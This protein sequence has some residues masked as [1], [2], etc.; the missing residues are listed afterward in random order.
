MAHYNCVSVEASPN[1]SDKGSHRILVVDDEPTLE[2]LIRL[3]MRREIR[4]GHFAFAF[5]RNGIEALARLSSDEPYDIVL[6]D[7]NMPKMDGLTL[8]EKIPGVAP[9]IRAVIV[10]AYG[11]M[12][13][14]RTAMNRGAFDFVTKPIDFADLRTTIDRTLRDLAAWREVLK[15]RD[16]LVAIERELELAR[17]MQ[18]SI[19]PTEFPDSAGHQIFARMDPAKA[20]GGDFFDFVNLG[21]SRVGLAIADVA[22][23]GVPA[24]LL[25]MSSRTLL[26]CGAIESNNPGKVLSYVNSALQTDNAA[27]MFVTMFYGIFDSGSGKFT[28][29]SAGHDPPLLVRKDGST[30]LLPPT[31]GTVLGVIPS[32]EYQCNAIDLAPGET[33]LLYTDGVPDAH[34]VHGERFGMERFRQVFIDAP[35]EC[36]QAATEVVFQAV[37]EFAQDTPQFDDVTCLVLR[38]LGLAS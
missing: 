17:R 30:S 4:S 7:I 37:R 9:D 32:L 36:A 13:N 15:S 38:R 24:A 19:L 10:S 16:Q 11:D 31:G 21:N 26:K 28:Y 20:V 25:M 29:A 2:R 5:A 1:T 3:R 18:R 35:P 33:I 6:S 34:N 14:I 23:K 12:K 8:L 27:L 22:G